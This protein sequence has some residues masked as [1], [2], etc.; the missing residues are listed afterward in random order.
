MA[1]RGIAVHHTTIYHWVQ[2]YALELEK[3]PLAVA[4]ATGAHLAGR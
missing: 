2:A 3:R 1:E 4:A